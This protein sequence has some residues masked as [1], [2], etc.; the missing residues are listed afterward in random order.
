MLKFTQACIDIT[1]LISFLFILIETKRLNEELF[2]KFIQ[3]S[4]TPPGIIF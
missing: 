1:S 2:R 3:S 4:L